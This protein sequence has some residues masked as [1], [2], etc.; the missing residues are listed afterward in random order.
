MGG[1]ESQEQE[2]EYNQLMDQVK[3]WDAEVDATQM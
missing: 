3:M 1:T 2:V